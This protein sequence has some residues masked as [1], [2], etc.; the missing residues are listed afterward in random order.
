MYLNTFFLILKAISG[1]DC[2]TTLTVITFSVTTFFKCFFSS[3]LSIV[4]ICYR[5][6][7]FIIIFNETKDI[8]TVPYNN[9]VLFPF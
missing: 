4:A 6:S 9:S 7:L 5:K 2:L 1:A 3:L 8:V